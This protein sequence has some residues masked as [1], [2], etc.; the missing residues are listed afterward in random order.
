MASIKNNSSKGRTYHL[1][2]DERQEIKEAFELFDID[3]TGNIV[4]ILENINGE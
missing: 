1:T 3:S 4:N 2:E